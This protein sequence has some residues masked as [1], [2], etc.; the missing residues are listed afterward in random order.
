MY[1]TPD[2]L[3]TIERETQV[4]IHLAS[5]LDPAQL[6]FR[7]GE[8][9]RS[10][11]EL[12]RYLTVCAIVPVACCIDDDWSAARDRVAAAETVTLENFAESMEA[13]RREVAERVSAL[14]SDDFARST[15]L[16]WGD[17]QPLG[18]ALVDTAVRFFS[19]YRFQLFLH[20]K[21]AG[22]TELSTMNAWLGMDPPSS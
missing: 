2:F 15:R 6:D 13:Q 12:L 5:K 14:S 22:R 11:E 17:T 9:L 1:Q 8:K 10:T 4:S 20:A 18:A 19:A 16:P 3:S 7:L 21:A